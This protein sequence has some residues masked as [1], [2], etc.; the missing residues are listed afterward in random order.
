MRFPKRYLFQLLFLLCV[1]IPYLDDY[2]LTF[3]VWI[4]TAA[5]SLV[6]SYSLG[7]IKFT[8][9]YI[10]IFIL[11]LIAT[12]SHGYKTYFII[13]DATYLLKPIM[14]ILIGY[15]LCR[16]IDFRNTFKT[17]VYTGVIIAICHYLVLAYAVLVLHAFTVNDIRLKAGM[18][19]D[20]EVYALI[21][22]LFHEK[23]ELDISRKRI[24]Y[25]AWIIGI[26]AFLYMA[27][28]NFIQFLILFV[29]MKGFLRINRT[30]LTAMAVVVGFV[31]VGYSAILYINPKRNGP[32]MEALLYKIKVAPV[33]PFKTKIDAGNWKDLNDNYRSYENIRTVKQVT[34][35][36]PKATYFGLGMGS[37]IDLKREIWLREKLRYISILHNGFM[38]VFLK[39]GL[40]GVLLSVISCFVLMRQR[41]SNVPILRNVNLL[42]LG[43][44]IFMLFSNWVFMGFYNLIDSKSILVGLFLCF[45]EMKIKNPDAALTPETD[46]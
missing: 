6:N 5:V 10:G 35:R 24:R 43:T 29:A 33:E 22:L 18:F 46:S 38:T 1:G 21:I 28:T 25:F 17:V 20:F 26:S 44:G 9:F 34:N 30:S 16:R 3:F 23:F 40:A 7:I 39:S 31:I 11:A 32:G 45:K 8:S 2:E 19:S 15:Q 13:R 37:R 4:F 14:G 27:R 42:L 12:F 36:G 41:K